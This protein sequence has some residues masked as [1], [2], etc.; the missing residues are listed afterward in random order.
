MPHSVHAVF[1]GAACLAIA[2]CAELQ[3]LQLAS[4]TARLEVVP[5]LV[6]G[7]LRSQALVAPW[8]PDE[9]VHVEIRL[10]TLQAA[11]TE[12]PALLQGQPVVHDLSRASL[13]APFTLSGLAP[14]AS[15]RLRARAFKA[16]GTATADMISDESR[17]F[18][19]VS[20]L[21]DDRPTVATLS[22]SLRDVAF[23]G[24]GTVPLL[25]LRPGLL[26]PV[27]SESLQLGAE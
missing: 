3:G 11:G 26:A 4:G 24:Q 16:Q 14:H 7:G 25:E 12:S 13:E 22:I 21:A 5:R 10:L 19:D 2:A 27:G 9:V 18:V 20:L 15:Y 1:L 8:T 23:D 6:S 17:S